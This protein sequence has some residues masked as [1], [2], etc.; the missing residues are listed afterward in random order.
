MKLRQYTVADVF[1]VVDMLSAI[2]G[3]AG[4]ELRNILRTGNGDANEADA[5][6]RGIELILYVLDKSYAGCKDKLIAWFASLLG[7]SVDDF[8]KKPPETV[9]DV[10]DEIANR[11]ESK[12]FFS[13]A[14][15]LFKK[16]RGAS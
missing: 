9:L 2:A 6:D 8:M 14:S 3:G 1:A 11:E 4:H 13:R 7:I 12:S 15:Q 5:E 10:I 16:R